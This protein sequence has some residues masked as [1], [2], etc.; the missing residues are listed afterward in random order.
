MIDFGQQLGMLPHHFSL[1]SEMA[2]TVDKIAYR[3]VIRFLTLEKVPPKEINQRIL[4]VYGNECPS[5]STVKTW[6]AETRRGR[7]FLED[8]DRQ[9]DPQR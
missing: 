5:Y 3:A 6:A 2:S 1:K 9:D 8:E 4:K 7:E